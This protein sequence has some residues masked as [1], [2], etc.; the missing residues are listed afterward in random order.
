MMVRNDDAEPCRELEALRDFYDNG[1]DMFFSV[2]VATSLVRD[3]NLTT[4]RRLDRTR[5]Q[6][7]GK[8]IT[9]LY[10]PSCLDTVERAFH[11]L[12]STGSTCADGLRVL[13]SDGSTIPV[14]LRETAIR[15]DRGEVSF[16]RSVWRDESRHQSA[17]KALRLQA[18]E[19]AIERRDSLAVLAGGVAHDFNNLLVGILGNAGLALMQIDESSPINGTLQKIESASQRATELVQQML[20]YSGRGGSE[21]ETFDIAAL[22]NEMTEL[23][24]RALNPLA[25]LRLEHDAEASWI[26]GDVRAIRQMVMNL[27]T[28]ASDA[29]TERGGIVTVRTGRVW[30]DQDFIDELYHAEDLRPGEY[31]LLE[32]RDTGCGMQDEVR[33]RMFDPFFS[34]KQGGRG[35]G[36]SAMLGTVRSN[37][38]AIQ[39]ET[40]VGTGTTITVLLP[41]ARA[42]VASRGDARSS[43][44]PGRTAPS[45]SAVPLSLQAAGAL[46]QDPAHK[47]GTVLVIDDNREV[48]EVLRSCL[49]ASGH[50]VI[51]ATSGTQG[52][53]KF[54]ENA[55][56]LIATFVDYAMPYMNGRVVYAHM[57]RMRADAL[58]IL[59]SG[60]SREEA[61]EGLKPNAGLH[62]LAK[63]FVP[64][65]LLAKLESA[66]AAH[67]AWQL[68][69]KSSSSLQA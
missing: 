32:V 56:R 39:V 26:F 62:F 48:C 38:G 5:E 64:T 34:T 13:R 42:E 7:V 25:R 49:E 68:R 14:S 8:S 33:A 45:S 22:V 66:R 11:E 31:G 19:Q 28:N 47:R 27:I 2:D 57:M 46:R 61:L 51:S 35:L 29:I 44:S 3:C 36:L 43:S 63:P 6:V 20:A 69:A 41:S 21:F 37:G 54:R 50:E 59:M 23:L 65:A 10:H 52:I 1:P 15:G 40:K 53:A 24:E 17:F 12:R 55:D 58:V 4:L 18:R 67:A 60:Y 30:A 16:T 9:Q